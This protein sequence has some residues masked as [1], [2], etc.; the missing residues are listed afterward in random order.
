MT[1]LYA[2]SIGKSGKHGNWMNVIV[3]TTI[4][5]VMISFLKTYVKMIFLMTI[6]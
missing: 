6:L 2:I 4:I 1:N 5:Q 3:A